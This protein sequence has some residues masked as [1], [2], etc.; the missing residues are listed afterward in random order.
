[1]K[2]IFLSV[3]VVATLVAAGVGGTLAD[4]SDIE[5][6]EDN[7]FKTGSLDLTVSDYAMNEY[8]GDEVPAF[9][10]YEGAWPCSD[11]SYF[12]DLENWGQGVQYK[13]WAYIH[14]KNVECCWVY[15]KLL[16]MWV[17]EAGEEVDAPPPLEGYDE[18]LEGHQGTG[19]PKPV[20]EPEYV[21][22][23]GGIAGEKAD[24]TLVVVDGIGSFGEGCELREHVSVMIE[25]AGPWPH[26]DKPEPSLD[27]SWT[28]VFNGKLIDL[29]CESIELMQLE[30]CNGM[31]VHIVFHLQE[32]TEE[33]F[34]FN[35]FDE[36][37]PSEAKWNDWV[38][39]AMQ[40]DGVHFDMAFELLQ[41]R[42]VP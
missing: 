19:F 17:N 20:T 24:G 8:N 22:E 32:P 37:I 29:E 38:T 26:A 15:P 40:K 5:V 42:Y 31:W 4:F 41:S 25:V 9:I 23:Y 6:S 34:G 2:N 33:D 11:K 13:P 18:W 27:L 1:M 7:Y 39:N 10:Q 30:N 35:Y 14:F 28:E 12:I 21:A 16:Y 36:N 3:V